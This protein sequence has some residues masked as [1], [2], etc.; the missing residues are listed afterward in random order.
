VLGTEGVDGGVVERR[1]RRCVW[2][3]RCVFARGARALGMEGVES[4]GVGSKAV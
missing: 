2:D 1:A 3:A 4:V